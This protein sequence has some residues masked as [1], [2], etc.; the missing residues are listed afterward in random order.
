MVKLPLAEPE[1][2]KLTWKK[3]AVK[4]EAENRD[5]VAVLL[6]DKDLHLDVGRRSSCEICVMDDFRLQG[7]LGY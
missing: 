1:R 3:V 7:W 5:P 4:I 2:W 6:S